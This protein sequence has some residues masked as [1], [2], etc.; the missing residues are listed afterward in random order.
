MKPDNSPA[1][2][3]AVSSAQTSAQTHAQTPTQRP[4]Q[5][6]ALT[7][8]L[9][10]RLSTLLDDA[11]DLPQ[12]ARGPWLA[13]LDTQDP[14][15]ASHLRALLVAHADRQA[16]D[17][18]ERGPQLSGPASDDPAAAA[19][20]HGLHAGQRVGPWRLMAPVGSG[21][22]ATVWR[23]ARAD[24]AYQR[25]V[26]LKLP[27]QRLLDPAATLRFEGECHILARL[28]HPHV[29]RLYDAHLY[30]AHLHDTGDDPADSHP[31]ALPWLAIEQVDGLPLDRWCEQQRLPVAQ[32]LALF[33]QVLQAVQYAH[34]HLVLHRDLK[35]SNILV[36]PQGQV[37]LLD[38]GIATLLHAAEAEPG[39][40]ARGAA[41]PSPRLMT[42][43]F[44]APEQIESAPLSTATDI[45]GA[46]V[47][48]FD[49]LTGA[50]PY[51]GPTQTPAE[52]EHAILRGPLWPAS[53]ACT[54]Q[55]AT[56]AGTTLPAL[57][58]ALAG[59]IDAILARALQREPAQRYPSA[60]AFAADLQRHLERRPVH[61]RRPRPG[62][63]LGRFIARHRAL[64]ALA[65]LGGVAAVCA[66]AA[67][68]VAA[69]QAQRAQQQTARALAAQAANEAGSAFMADL[70]ND[71]MR[72]GQPI[73]ADE[74]LARAERMARQS[75]AGKPDQ[76]AAVLWMVAQRAGDW[77]GQERSRTLVHEALA[78][79]QDRDLRDHLGC[80]DAYAQAQLGEL[81]AATQRLQTLADKPQALPTAR[82]CA[83]GHLAFMAGQGGHLPEALAL[84]QNA[85]AQL[86]QARGV[87]EHVRAA[88]TARLALFKG[89]LGQGAES[90]R[91]FARALALMADAGRER[92]QIAWAVR[93][94]WSIALSSAGDSRRALALGQQNLQWMEDGGPYTA[95]ML[96]TARGVGLTALAAGQY[97]EAEAVFDRSLAQARAA[98]AETPEILRAIECDRVLLATRTGRL[99]QAAQALARADAVPRRDSATDIFYD[100]GC[101]LARAEYDI[102][103]GAPAQA[104]AALD[105]VLADA[106]ASAP[107]WQ[108]HA[109][110]L[111]ARAHLALG[112]ATAARDEAQRALAAAQGL[113]AGRPHSV[114]TGAAQL[115]LGAALAAAGD[116][117]AAATALQQAQQQ[118]Q[119]SVASTHPW[120]MDAQS[121]LAALNMAATPASAASR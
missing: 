20:A 15:T 115:W 45:Y 74:W 112:Q 64:V 43:A 70:L 84:Q 102:T 118:L 109:R 80:E 44:A 106:G 88:A 93:N 87:P 17:R 12:A 49:L 78:L 26:A 98:G 18:L 35:A 8:E 56:A 23:A 107:P 4:A 95:K 99:D 101:R 105:T 53:Q 29:A 21:G 14:A 6:S 73:Q 61:A 34:S 39:Q 90:D 97:A 92:S 65:A 46:G 71:A 55:A 86:D 96:Y 28:E 42:P 24:G 67:L 10:A 108:W 36:T 68:S 1:P 52:L 69:W 79:A 76:L 38:F 9:W 33:V 104:L 41:A 94:E 16:A 85:V 51:A 19:G 83:M 91:L 3:P 75:F 72:A 58:R 32:R 114:R 63:V 60:Q 66:T 77:D 54:A 25:E 121:R 13:A 59:D 31:A 103:R 81:A 47:V 2:G 50:R 48:L 111:A 120:L 110:V 89:Q 40:S 113:Q 5:T 116:T 57:R 11:L 30:D 62:Y 117:A 22:M 100:R 82:A 27:R 119:G 7:P 37:K